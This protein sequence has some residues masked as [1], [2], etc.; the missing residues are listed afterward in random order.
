M[1]MINNKIAANL[2]AAIKIVSLD[3]ANKIRS[4]R[5]HTIQLRVEGWFDSSV[6]AQTCSL[7]DKTGVT[8]AG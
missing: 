8:L 7:M 2:L 4:V 3:R 6:S 5:T 1:K